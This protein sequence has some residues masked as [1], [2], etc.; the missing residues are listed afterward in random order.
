MT[1]ASFPEGVNELLRLSWGVVFGHRIFRCSDGAQPEND[2][3][4]ALRSHVSNVSQKGLKGSQVSLRRCDISGCI[5]PYPHLMFSFCFNT[6]A[7]TVSASEFSS[8]LAIDVIGQMGRHGAG[9]VL[10]LLGPVS[11]VRTVFDQGEH[12]IRI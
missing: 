4:C 8:S 3:N 12:H 5:R 2:S 1:E 9:H 6:S 10:P 7:T 11:K